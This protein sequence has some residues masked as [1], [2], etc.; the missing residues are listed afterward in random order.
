MPGI[1]EKV[2]N[3]ASDLLKNELDPNFLYHNLKHTE[4]VVRSTRE[5]I[6]AHDLS[7]EDTEALLLT[8]WLHDTGYTKGSDN[9]EASSSAIAEEFLKN[10]KYPEAGIKRV[11]ELIM[12]TMRYHT[13]TDQLEKI[14]RDADASHFAKKSYMETC[15]LLR[16][17][18][19]LLGLADY[20]TEDWLD[21]NLKMLNTEHQFYTDFAKE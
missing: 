15:E 6:S 5:L 1:V 18:L 16:E 10:E 13:P 9:H 21:A 14:I 3:F 20:T 8:A 12:A 17:E 4:R 11:Q 19:L 7:N 2:E